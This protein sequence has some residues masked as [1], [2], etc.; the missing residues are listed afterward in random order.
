MP[1]YRCRV[2]AGSLDLD[3]RQAIAR[4]FTDI[5]CDSTGAPRN[6][7][8]VFFADHDDGGY[9]LAGSNRA[10]RPAEVREALLHRLCGALAEAAGVARASVGGHISESPASWSMEAGEILPEPG[11]EG[12]AWFAGHAAA[13]G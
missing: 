10:G 9:Y 7:V 11:E 12:P 1:V 3:Q 8:H 2:P 5:H 6:F 4:R 13:S